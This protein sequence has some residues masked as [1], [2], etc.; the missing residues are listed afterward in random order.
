MARR[1]IKGSHKA[2]NNLHHIDMPGLQIPKIHDEKGE[3]EDE[4]PCPLGEDHDPFSAP[5]VNERTADELEQN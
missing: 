2:N 5:A 1:N 4:A 3:K